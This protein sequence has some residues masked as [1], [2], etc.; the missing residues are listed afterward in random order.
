MGRDNAKVLLDEGTDPSHAK[1]LARIEREFPG[2]SF[3]IVA[4]EYLAKLRRENR[5]D[6]TMNKLEWLLGF[7]L[8]VLGPMSVS[9]IRPIDVLAVLRTVEKRG[10]YD[11]ARRLRATIGAVCRYAV[12]TARAQIDPPPRCKGR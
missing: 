11:S 5:A 9:A 8:P 12:A 3:E 10:R 4:N 1:R 2:D 6:A 7:A